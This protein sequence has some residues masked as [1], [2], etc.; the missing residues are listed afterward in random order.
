LPSLPA[1]AVFR[2]LPPQV[3]VTVRGVRIRTH[4]PHTW[5]IMSLGLS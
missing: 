1:G 2:N 3:R 4:D 5:L